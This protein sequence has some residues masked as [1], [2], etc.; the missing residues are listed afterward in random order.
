VDPLQRNFSRRKCVA[1]N[2]GALALLAATDYVEC[3]NARTRA[4]EKKPPSDEEGIWGHVLS[5]KDR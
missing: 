5:K 2:A 3:S 4:L 1:Q